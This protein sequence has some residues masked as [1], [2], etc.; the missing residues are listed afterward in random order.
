MKTKLARML[1]GFREP[2]R[3]WSCSH[4]LRVAKNLLCFVLLWPNLQSCGKRS[5]GRNRVPYLHTA[6]HLPDIS[7]ASLCVWP[8]IVA[9]C[10][11]D[12]CIDKI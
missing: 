9:S 8:E 5:V 4:G 11:L 6:T 10:G 7:G 3:K 12:C 1:C 2:F